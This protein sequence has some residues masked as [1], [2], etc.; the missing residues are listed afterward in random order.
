[1]EEKISVILVNYNGLSYNDA[2]IESLLAS[3]GCGRLQIVVVDNASTDGSY[4]KLQE[5]W[6]RHPQVTLVQAERNLGFAGG[7]N[8]GIRKALETAPDFLMLLNNDTVIE[9]DAIGH[10]IALQKETGGI[11]APK[12]LYAD[13][14]DIVWSAGGEFSPV[15]A[16]SRHIGYNKPDGPAYDEDCSCSFANGCCFLMSHS[17]FD[18]IGY[19]D[20]RFFLYYED[21]EYS[22]RAVSGNISIWYCHKAVVYHKVN[23]ATKGNEKAANAYYIARNWLLCARM[24][25][26]KRF[27]LFLAY[28]LLN[29]LVWVVLWLLRGR[30]DMV[31]ATIEAWK[32][33]RRGITG[34]YRG[35]CR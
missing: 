21:N 13:R 25:L 32:D 4:A 18:K 24:Y 28:F 11:V 35:K 16:K 15:I 34:P 6:G 3:T 31:T 8:I 14:R 7:N 27:A 23:G 29:R 10:L 26:G 1:M 22:L 2:C 17:V 33:Y 12:I 9:P 30:R 19:M 5:R 20:E